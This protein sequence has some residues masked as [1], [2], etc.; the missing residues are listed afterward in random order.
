MEGRTIAQGMRMYNDDD[1]DG[2]WQFV[3]SLDDLPD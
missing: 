3:G 2:Y 1:D